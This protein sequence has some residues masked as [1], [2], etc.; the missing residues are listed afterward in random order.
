MAVKTTAETIMAAETIMVE[1]IMAA[2]ITVETIMVAMTMVAMIWEILENKLH[3][4]FK[5]NFLNH[6]HK[7]AILKIYTFYTFFYFFI[8]KSGLFTENKTVVTN[9]SVFYGENHGFLLTK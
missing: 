3:K 6:E 2:I 1:T 9:F 4:I 7:L 8:F 5:T